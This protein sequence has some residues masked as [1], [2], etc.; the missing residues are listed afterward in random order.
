[1]TLIA[2]AVLIIVLIGV[3]LALKN[4]KTPVPQKD[5]TPAAPQVQKPEKELEEILKSLLDLNLLIRKDADFPAQ[6]TR[7]IE[8]VMD[9]LM[10]ITPAMMDRYPGETLTYEIKKIGKEH[11][12]KTV[13]EYLDLSTDSREHQL[14]MFKQTIDSLKEVSNRSRDIVEKN[15]TAEFK[16][17]ANFLSSKF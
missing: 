3:V 13:K 1:M 6:L 8:A 12:F 11:L 16:T 14:D 5:D 15:E 7:E 4:R 17:M 10:I 2:A 9:D